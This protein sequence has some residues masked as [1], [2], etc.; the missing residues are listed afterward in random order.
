MLVCFVVVI[1]LLACVCVCMCAE[2][3]IVCNYTHFLNVHFSTF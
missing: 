2:F 3:Y 1:Y